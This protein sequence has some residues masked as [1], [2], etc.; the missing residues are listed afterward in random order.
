MPRLFQVKMIREPQNPLQWV[1]LDMVK[2]ENLLRVFL[3]WFTLKIKVITGSHPRY[4]SG[5]AHTIH[6]VSQP[7][8]HPC[9]D[10]FIVWYAH[11]YLHF[12][13]VLL[14]FMSPRNPHN[15]SVFLWEVTL[16]ISF[17]KSA[18]GLRCFYSSIRMSLFYQV[19]YWVYI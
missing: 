13:G 18:W 1:H 2:H 17:E 14:D 4:L 5:L 12:H 19:C 16:W 9:C 3:W 7:L 11:G 6:V 15:A 10:V 8:L